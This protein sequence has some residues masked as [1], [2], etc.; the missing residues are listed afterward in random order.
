MAPI[1]GRATGRGAWQRSGARPHRALRGWRG[2]RIWRAKRAEWSGGVGRRR[3]LLAAKPP[4]VVYEGP[5][6]FKATT[7]R[8]WP[9]FRPVLPRRFSSSVPAWTSTASRQL[10]S[11]RAFRSWLIA[12]FRLPFSFARPWVL[13]P[14][15]P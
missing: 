5:N 1:A 3:S 8:S 14:P 11:V 13:L 4:A 6:S 15:T 12:P 9:A 2:P 10:F 7:L